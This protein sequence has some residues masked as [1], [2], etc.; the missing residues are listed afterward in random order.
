MILVSARSWTFT[1]SRQR[2][3]RPVHFRLLPTQGSV[4][5][6]H[7]FEIIHRSARAFGRLSHPNRASEARVVLGGRRP[8]IPLPMPQDLGSR[9]RRHSITNGA[10]QVQ[11]TGTTTGDRLY[12]G[13]DWFDEQI[14]REFEI[15]FQSSE[16]GVC[17]LSGSPRTAGD[18]R[19]DI[20]SMPLLILVTSLRR[21]VT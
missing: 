18:S 4:P 12:E 14:N 10:S 7:H 1:P 3:K 15:I 16:L 21:W 19:G 2:S 6:R 9:L 13:F 8:R 5:T 11:G 17:S 20:R